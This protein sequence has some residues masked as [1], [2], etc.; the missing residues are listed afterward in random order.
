[1]PA[2]ERIILHIDDDDDDRQLVEEAIL[3]VDPSLVVQQ[4]KNGDQG[5]ALLRQLVTSENAPCLVVID[6]NMPGMD[7][8]Q[9]IIEIKKEVALNGIPLVIFTT[10]SNEMDK[11]FANRENIELIVKP[12]SVSSLQTAIRRMLNLAQ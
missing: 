6:L 11:L 2:K 10:S 4:A 1:M 12:P 8:K 9:L 5:L 3:E 7:G